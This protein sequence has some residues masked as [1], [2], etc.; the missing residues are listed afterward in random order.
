MPSRFQLFVVLISISV[1]GL[2]QAQNIRPITPETIEFGRLP[3]G[4]TV[5]GDIRFTNAGSVPVQIER[6]QA[7]CGCT[8]TKIEKMTVVSGD[9]ASIH[10]AVRTQGFRGVVRKTITVFFTD[11]KEKEL[12]FVIKGT[13][14]SDLEV[15]PSFI[16]FQDVAIDMNSTVT[17]K[18]TVKN[19]TEKPVQITAV[20]SNSD[21]LTVSPGKISIPAGQSQVI[22]VTLKPLRATTQDTDL[23]IE[24]DSSSMPKIAI[25]VFIQVGAKK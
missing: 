19:Q 8:T 16:D 14:Y 17:Q 11:P 1:I 2:L 22:Q 12:E 3:E 10:Y 9:T 23:W 20:R 18:V 21:L 6:V 7:S 4:R 15:T 25:P 13:L 24:T 5:E